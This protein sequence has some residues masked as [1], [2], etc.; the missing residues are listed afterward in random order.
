L[1]EPTP[2]QQ[3]L[4]TVMLVAMPVIFAA[5]SGLLAMFIPAMYLLPG[6]FLLVVITLIASPDLPVIEYGCLSV[7]SLLLAAML[8][9]FSRYA[10]I[11]PGTIAGYIVG[12][13]L[14]QRLDQVNVR[15]LAW[16]E[17]NNS[18]TSAAD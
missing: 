16:R 5:A 2:L 12:L 1:K 9:Y 6:L 14:G 13:A 15:Y 3:A 8:A 17:E 10:V 18:K 4:P 7:L 11:V